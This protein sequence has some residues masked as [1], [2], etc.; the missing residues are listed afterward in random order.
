MS[1]DKNDI[2]QAIKQKVIELADQLG[3]DASDLDVEEVIPASGYIDSAALLELIAWF[4][5]A[6]GIRVPPADLTIDN[7]G[8]AAQMADYLLRRK[9]QA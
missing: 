8:S 9:S 7:L 5:A 1:L 6:Y 3:A 4:E 2:Q